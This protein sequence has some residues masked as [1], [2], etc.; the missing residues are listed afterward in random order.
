[1]ARASACGRPTVYIVGEVAPRS[2]NK[3]VAPGQEGVLHGSFAI[4]KRAGAH[5]LQLKIS[6]AIGTTNANNARGGGAGHHRYLGV[7]KTRKFF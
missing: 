2:G 6:N 5:K 7:K 1:M 3:D 4:E